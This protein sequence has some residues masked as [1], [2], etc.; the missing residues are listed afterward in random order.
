MYDFG[1]KTNKIFLVYITNKKLQ[2]IQIKIEM[3]EKY[4]KYVWKLFSF[5]INL[6]QLR[7]IA[8]KCTL[9]LEQKKGIVIS[10]KKFP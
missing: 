9:R 10:L 5:D 2:F 6:P 3:Y 4:A 1:S 8:M 7:S